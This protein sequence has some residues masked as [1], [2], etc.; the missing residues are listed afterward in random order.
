MEAAVGRRDVQSTFSTYAA[1]MALTE[2]GLSAIRVIFQRMHN[3][4]IYARMVTIRIV[5]CFVILVFAYTPGPMTR[6][7]SPRHPV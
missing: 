6:P 4:S 1:N 3:Y 7:P 5:V 2:P